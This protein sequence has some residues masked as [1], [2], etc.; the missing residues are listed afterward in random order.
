MSHFTF[1]SLKDL[2]QSHLPFT[3]ITSDSRAVKKGSVFVAVP[4]QTVD[5]HEFILSAQEQGA[6]V[7]VGEQEAPAGLKVPYY[8]V[9]DSALALA[10]LAADFYSH[11]SR[12]LCVVG[13]TGTSGKTTTSYLM[14]SILKAAG[15]QVGVIGTVNFRYGSTILPSSHTTPG[16]VELQALLAQMK[17]AGCTAIVME[18]SSHALKQKRSHGIAFDG[19]IFTNL[20]PEHLD[21]HPDMEDYYSSKALLFKDLCF[22][23]WQQGKKPVAAINSADSYGARLISEVSQQNTPQITSFSQGEGLRVSLSGITGQVQGIQI[24]SLMTGSFNAAN[25]AAAVTLA[26]ALGV[27]HDQISKGVSHLNAVPGRLERVLDPHGI[28]VWVDYAHKPDA[29]DKVIA[30]LRE[31]RSGHRLITVFGCGG[32]RDR[33]KRPVM[34][35]IAVEGSD[36]VVITSD[37]PRTENPESIIQEILHGTTGYSNFEVVVDR[38]LAIFRAIALAQPGDLV[39]IAGKGHEDYQI[40][41]KTKIHFDDREVALMALSTRW[42]E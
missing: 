39:L 2:P 25:I 5:G 22:S 10:Q 34:G 13:I 16:P 6:S 41:G 29:L 38:K 15:H 3:G 24:S 11:P 23:S 4:G 32:D 19:V 31:V 33:T 36:F 21:F 18:V 9:K 26:Q 14:E 40:L 42:G 20:S 28:H 17:S 35:K 30:T 37:N 27:P 1:L 7:V 8:Q 12:S